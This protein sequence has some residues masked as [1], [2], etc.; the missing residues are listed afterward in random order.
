MSEKSYVEYKQAGFTLIELVVVI[1]VLGILSA[2]AVPRFVNMRREAIISTMHG[3]NA[4]LESAATLA[5]AKACV[6]GVNDQPTASIEVQGT[7]VNLVY[8][9]PA[10]TAG[11]ISQMLDTPVGDWKQRAS[12]YDGAWV[13]WHGVIDED[14]GSAQC[15]LRYRQSTGAGS[16][17][18]IDL[19]DRGC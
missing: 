1:V 8:G 17:P 18:V 7:T 11:G 6:N 13:Y 10:G 19:Q 5:H 4:S 9:Y 12:T 16:R 3:L 2:T 14:A 15:Y